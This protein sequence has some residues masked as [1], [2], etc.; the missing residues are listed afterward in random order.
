MNRKIILAIVLVTVAIFASAQ[1]A[2]LHGYMDYTNF[3]VGQDFTKAA[4]ADEWEHTEAAAEY[5]SFYNGRT[6]INAVV[7]AANFQFNL[8][9]RMNASLGTWYD[10][11]ASTDNLDSTTRVATYFHQGNMRV[12]FFNDQ[13]RIYTGKY[14]EWSNGY[15]FNGFVLGGQF[16]RDLCIRGSGQHFTGVE[17]SPYTLN[18]FKFMVGFPILPVSGNGVQSSYANQW[19]NLY[20]KV[21]IV[22]SYKLPTGITFNFGWRPETHLEGEEKYSDDSYF[23]EAYLQA[24][25]PY[26]IPDVPLN[27]SYDF[28]YRNNEAVD[29]FVTMHYFGF[30]GKLPLIGDLAISFENRIVYAQDHYVTNNE[31]ALFEIFGLTG[32]YTVPGTDY[33]IGMNLHAAYAQDAN[34]TVFSTSRTN[35]FTTT[36]DMALVSEWMT[37]A[38]AP[39]S[40]SAGRYLGVYAYPYFQKNFANGYFRTGIEF[41]YTRFETSNVTQAICYRVPVA[42]C[43]WY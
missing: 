4:G 30:S 15:V 39:A 32:I 9:I 26:L 13:L 11:Y 14:E 20:K 41:Q 36:D 24:D 6:E 38:A 5:G 10:L 12:G 25:M 33:V 35:G 8:G 23:G 43:F 3:A 18:G 34:G 22:G 27:V 1:T 7:E 37:P 29:K 17:I 28:R 2:A 16:I 19:A 21:K 31:E 40:G 42:L